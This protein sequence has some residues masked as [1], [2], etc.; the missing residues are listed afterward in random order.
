VTPADGWDPD[1]V[2]V[3]WPH[4]RTVDLRRNYGAH[5]DDGGLLEGTGQSIRKLTVRTPAALGDP[6]LVPLLQAARTERLTALGRL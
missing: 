3:V 4:R 2:R 6:R 1:V 5:L